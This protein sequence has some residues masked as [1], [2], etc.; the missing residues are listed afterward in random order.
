MK[1]INIRRTGGVIFTL[2]TFAV[3][4]SSFSTISESPWTAPTSADQLKNPLAGNAEATKEGKKLYKTYCGLCHGETGKGDGVA[5]VALNPKPARFASEAVQAQ[6]DGALFWKMTEGRAPMASY[7]AVLKEEQ[8]WA[9]VNYIR[10][11]KK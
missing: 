9:L 3:V 6:T 11:F 2:L 7:R 5:A 8:R 1:R 4:A 10:T